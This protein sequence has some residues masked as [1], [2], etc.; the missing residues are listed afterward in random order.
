MDGPKRFNIFRGRHMIFE[1]KTDSKTPVVFTIAN[2]TSENRGNYR[3]VYLLI[4]SGKRSDSS[5]VVKVTVMAGIKAPLTILHP[6]AADIITGGNL[7]M[8]CTATSSGRCFYYQDYDDT[9]S[10][11]QLSEGRSKATVSITN[12]SFCD[13]GN[14]T[15][16]CLVEVNGAMVYSAR[17]NLMPL[18]VSDRPE[19]KNKASTERT[20]RPEPKNKAS[21]ERTYRPEPKNKASTE[22]TS[23]H[24][25]LAL[26]LVCTA[27]LVLILTS[28]LLGVV[29]SKRKI[30]LVQTSSTDETELQH[31]SD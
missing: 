5:N 20:Y 30:A 26:S 15:C 14:Y 21:T 13:E 19:P 29:L 9:V 8:S 28:A 4:L 7:S 23:Y 17:S 24:L 12:L 1:G 2:V 27:L 25:T 18:T 31:I 16:Q 10:N 3:C 6:A 11:F 22:R